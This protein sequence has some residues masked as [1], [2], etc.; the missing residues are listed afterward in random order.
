MT[1]YHLPNGIPTGP[2]MT[3]RF[4]PYRA[5]VWK[6]GEHPR[7]RFKIDLSRVYRCNG[8]YEHSVGLEP[9]HLP[10]D[11]TGQA[12]RRLVNMARLYIG[13]TIHLVRALQDEETT[14]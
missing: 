9:K 14:P 8:G 13:A 6:H 5:S 11:E 3:W 2:E 7:P 10:H 4:G 12:P 1:A